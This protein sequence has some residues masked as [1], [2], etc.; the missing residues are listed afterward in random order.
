MTAARNMLQLFRLDGKKAVLIG[1]G[2]LGHAAAIALAQAGAHV[3]IL[4]Y[5]LELADKSVQDIC[6]Q[7]G[8]AFALR[9]DVTDESVMEYAFGQAVERFGGLDIMVNASG[10]GVPSNSLDVPMA[11][12]QHTV[13]INLSGVFLAARIAARS[14]LKKGGA[15]VNISSIMGFSG[16]G[17]RPGNAAYK[18]TKGGVVNLTRALAFE[19][20]QHMIRVN[21]VAPSWVRTPLIEDWLEDPG[22]VAKIK[23]LV[24][25]GRI[26][27][28]EEIATAI[29][30]LASPAASMVTGHTLVVDGGFLAA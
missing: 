21:A 13:D 22:N 23:A 9:C 25:L 10:I 30:Y 18:A 2:G 4:D 28:P 19:W 11:E 7:G 14:M 26:A 5:S 15:I 1:A 29:L 27:E 16:G 20:A 8:T 3:A 6:A 17:F 12:W 24:P